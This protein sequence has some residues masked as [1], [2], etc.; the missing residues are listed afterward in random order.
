MWVDVVDLRDFYASPRGRV[1]RRLIS[2]HIRDLWTNLTGHRLLGLGYATP[3]L[4]SLRDDA[5]RT[6]A[7]MPV[8]QGVARW[9]EGSAGLV[10]LTEEQSLPFPDRSIDRL[11]L[12]HCLEGTA[13]PRHLMR[14]CWRVMADGGRLL[15]VVANRRGLWARAETSPWAHGRPY[16]MGQITRLL[17]DGLFAPVQSA[18]ALFVPPVWWRLFGAWAASLDRL[19][20]RWFPTFAGVIL[21]EAE[22]QI[23]AAPF[24]AVPA[25]V[26]KAA[27]A[28]RRPAVDGIGESFS[29]EE[30][31]RAINRASEQTPLVR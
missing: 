11:L 5:E 10:C 4:I 26:R 13:D 9:P 6:L 31:A 28:V 3:Y 18:T 2:R 22:K 7:A 12:V 15:V 24:D 19:G 25:K 27:V 8:G 30:A 29:E 16:S 20:S 14:E 21:I 23:Y 1:A 17:R